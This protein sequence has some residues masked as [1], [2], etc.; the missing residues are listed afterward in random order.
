[1]DGGAVGGA[2]LG[3]LKGMQ[4]KK[5]YGEYGEV[6]DKSYAFQVTIKKHL[7]LCLC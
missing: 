3:T 5:R 4:A 6:R 1:M 7:G 2:G